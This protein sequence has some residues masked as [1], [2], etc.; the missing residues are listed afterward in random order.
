MKYRPVVFTV[1][2]KVKDL[3]MKSG[4]ECDAALL[5]TEKRCLM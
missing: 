3:K 2:F 4:G 5:S 1:F